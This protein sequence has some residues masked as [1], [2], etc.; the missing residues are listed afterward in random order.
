MIEAEVHQ[1][2]RAFL[3]EQGVPTWPHHLTMARLVARAFRLG[4]SALMQVGGSERYRL[5]YLVPALMWPGPV[6]IVAAE[7]T[8]QRLL[9]IEIPRLQQIMSLNKPIRTES[10]WPEGFCGLLFTTP[11]N[12]LK[13]HLSGQS[14]FPEGVPVLIDSADDLEELAR[15]ALT[16]VIQP[17][18]WDALLLACPSQAEDIR[19]L[20]VSLTQ[21]IFRHPESPYHCHLIDQP[22]RE[23]LNQLLSLLED[24]PGTA[25]IA[26]LPEAWQQFWQLWQAEDNLAWAQVSRTHGQFSLHASPIEIGSVLQERVWSKQPLVVVGAALDADPN[27]VTYRTRLGLGD[28]TCLQFGPARTHELIQLYLPDGLPMPNTPQFQVALLQELRYLISESSS[29]QGLVVVIVGDV[30]LKAQ[31]GSVLASEF[32]SRVQVE[33]TCLDDNGVLV[34]G[35]KFWKEHQR[36]LPAPQLL[37][38]AT[39]PIPSLE[40]PLVAGRVAHY[41]HLRQDWFRLYL[42]PEALSTLQRAVVPVRERQGVVAILDNRVLH[43]SYGGQIINALNPAARISYLDPGLFES[44]SCPILD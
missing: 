24:C 27:A 8:Q 29:T 18:H 1:Q 3:R 5:S 35:W 22:E 10:A 40:D 11:Q 30:P 28:M 26:A 16:S 15:D 14:D 37:A 38:I 32:G 43:R 33:R 20:R 2:L 39:L 31:V 42:L 34:T 23:S 9:Q 12:W 36:V 17:G 4:R 6:I 25:G 41:K 13:S 19:S 44:D 21:Q 7:A